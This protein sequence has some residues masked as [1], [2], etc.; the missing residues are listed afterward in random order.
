MATKTFVSDGQGGSL[1]KVLIQHAH[2]TGNAQLTAVSCATETPVRLCY[3]AC[4][5]RPGSDVPKVRHSTIF[6]LIDLAGT[7]DDTGYM[8]FPA[9]GNYLLDVESG[10]TSLGSGVVT[11]QS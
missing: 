7:G 6:I 8:L 11:V 1:T 5:I 10:G 2:G 9:P 3:G 4:R